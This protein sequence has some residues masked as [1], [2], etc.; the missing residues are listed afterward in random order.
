MKKNWT[1]YAAAL[2]AVIPLFSAR[3]AVN[4]MAD[5]VFVVDESGSMAGEHN[6]LGSMAAGF[7]TQLSTAGVTDARFSLIGYG[8]GGGGNNGRVVAGAN[9]VT[10]ALFATATGSLVTSGSQ[11]D[12]YAGINYALSNVTMR[13]GAALN[14]ILVTDEDRDNATANTYASIL[15]ALTGN[16]ALLNVVVNNGFS[17]SGTALGVDSSLAAYKADGLGGFT[18]TADGTGLIGSGVGATKANYIDM[19]LAT[20]GAA[21]DLNQLRLAGN[22]AASFTAAFTS[23]KVAEIVSQPPSRVPDSGATIGLFLSSLALVA[24]LRRK[25]KA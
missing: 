24:G 19:A 6:W 15:A 12:G 16:G 11:E 3:A 1:V 22:T 13:G 9:S 18:A 14:V 2:L 5:I 8:G 17:S 7:N 20:G 4:T 21:W 10:A 25:F 23:I